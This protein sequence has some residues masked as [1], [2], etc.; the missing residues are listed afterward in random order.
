VAILIAPVTFNY[1][2]VEFLLYR[3]VRRGS[4]FKFFYLI[5]SA[6]VP[7]TVAASALGATPRGAASASR[8]S[9]RLS[10][11]DDS[12]FFTIIGL[13]AGCGSVVIST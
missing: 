11:G 6:V 2:E 5:T 9:N 7:A 4:V 12:L 8:L 3:S 13:G 10:L 1:R